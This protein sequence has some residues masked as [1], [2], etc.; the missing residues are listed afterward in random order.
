MK[1]SQEKT[2]LTGFAV[3]LCVLV[4]LGAL[5]YWMTWQLVQSDR[6][7]AHTD[8]VLA[9]IHAIVAEARGAESA[10]RGYVINGDRAMLEPYRSAS[11]ALPGH[12]QEL[13]GLVADN[14]V[15]E[16]R[17]NSLEQFMT[18]RLAVLEK[19]V[20]LRER[21]GMGAV[22]TYNPV[23][24]GTEI[25]R[26][27]LA[28][29][30]QMEA[31]ETGLQRQRSNAASKRSRE[32]SELILIATL[33]AIGV[34]WLAAAA[35]R[36]D[37]R[38]RLKITQALEEAHRLYEGLFES[39]ADALLL[40]DFE[41]RVVRVNAEAERVFGYG[42]GELAGHPVDTLVPERFR[43]MH[44]TDR[45]AY[46]A[47]PRA[48]AMGAGRELFG[49]RKDGSEFPVEVMLSTSRAGDQ[50]LVMSIVRDIS[51]H[52]RAEENLRHY[53]EELKQS[54]VELARSNADLESFAY[55]ASH[56]LQEPLRM[57]SKYVQLLGEHY[58]GKLDA[59]ADEFIAYA[60]DGAERMRA[61]IHD[62]LSYSRVSRTPARQE[63]VD[64]KTV[65]DRALANLQQAIQESQ[66][67]ITVDPLPVVKGDS[68]QLERLFQNLIGN[69]VKYRGE[70]PPSI[71]VS[72]RQEGDWTFCIR[73]NGIGIDPQHRERIFGMFQR[74]HTRQEYAGTGIGLAVCK[75]VVEGHGGRIWVESEPGRGSS[76]FFTL[77]AI[78]AEDAAH[79]AKLIGS[80]AE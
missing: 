34:L 20:E 64:C 15:Q 40:S 37:S 7:V 21:G 23:P 50:P 53:A 39:S 78:S 31:E 60:V 59:Q 52:K 56:D 45:Q 72:A 76:F 2:L 69:A 46:Y 61:L 10:V 51:E 43:S 28:V 8:E 63:M 79:A 25:M 35:L 19:A 68:S 3:A 22:Q 58:R 57:V 41:G 65:V 73:D 17:A 24:I 54:S 62:F 74:L 44:W 75:R 18:S 29:A 33:A 9:K 47:E 66:A 5:Q 36:R 4:G 11:G 70:R 71:R 48:R 30:D 38:E 13:K 42:R 1:T 55:V 26:R 6:W 49:R 80:Q 12:L 67:G 27:A 77:P 16:Q 32:T 14:P